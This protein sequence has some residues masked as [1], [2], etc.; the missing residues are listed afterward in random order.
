MV[1]QKCEFPAAPAK[2]GAKG[3]FIQPPGIGTLT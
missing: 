3:E 2:N 1:A